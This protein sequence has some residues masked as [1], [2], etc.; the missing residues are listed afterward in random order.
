MIEAR[1]LWK[2][3]GNKVVL[4]R[5][6]LRVEEGEFIT[7]VGTSGCGKSTFLNM[8]LGTEPVSSGELLLHGKPVPGEPG[9]D[10]GIVFQQYSVFPHMTVLQNVMAA[11][12]FSR[13]NLTGAL[14]GSARRAA[15]EEA[16]ALLEE[17]GLSHAQGQYPAELSGGR[18]SC[19]AAN[20]S[21]SPSPRR[22]LA[23]PVFSFSTSRSVP[24]TPVSG[25]T[26][27]TSCCASGASTGSRCSWSPTISRR[28]STW[29]PDSGYS[30]RHDTIPRHPTP[31]ARP[32]PTTC[33]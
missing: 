23:A 6:N 29:V 8:L 30:T 24:W 2:K 18:R 20:A 33:R 10:R 21:V 17:V 28:V 27:T 3:Y 16:L 26:C 22:C 15:R 4:E 19:P 1:N 12:G 25:P 7:L 9:P 31:M 5:I 14:F 13:R 11:R 32:S